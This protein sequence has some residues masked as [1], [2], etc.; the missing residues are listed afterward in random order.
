MANRLYLMPMTG[1]GTHEDKRRP[2]YTDSIF[3]PNAVVWNQ[4]DFGYRPVSLVAAITTN[5]VHTLLIANADVYAFP[6]GF[7]AGVLT[8][9]TQAT[10]LTNTLENTFAIPAQWVASQSTY[11]SVAHTVG[12]MFQFMQRL[13]GRIGNIDPFAGA[14]LNTQ[15]RNLAPGIGQAIMDAGASFGW[16]MSGISDQTTLRV[17]IKY[18]ADQWGATPLL[19]GPFNF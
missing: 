8:V 12:A 15:L 13:N 16:N 2:K 11:A 9:G 1:V 19:L 10:T 18:M 4:F 7:E 5:P 14:P 17:G 6:D 3:T